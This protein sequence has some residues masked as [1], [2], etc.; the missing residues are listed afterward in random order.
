MRFKGYSQWLAEAPTAVDHPMP[1]GSF[2]AR[3]LQNMSHV[4]G[5]DEVDINTK[6][7]VSIIQDKRPAD[8]RRLLT[9]M[10]AS[11]N[12]DEQP[13]FKREVEDYNNKL[14]SGKSEP[15]THPLDMQA[16][17]KQILVKP[18]SDGS[19]GGGVE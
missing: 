7:L 19:G 4:G 11:G 5:D 10:L 3:A 14:G 1:A 12:F 9:K 6:R 16:K 2:R 8:F 15:K 17:D 18:H 13:D